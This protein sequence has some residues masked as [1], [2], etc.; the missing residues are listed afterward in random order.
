MARN[1][2]DGARHDRYWM[3]PILR[4]VVALATA[5]VITFTAGHSSHF[6]LNVFGAF[7]LASGLVVGIASI[8]LVSEPVTRAFFV[9]Q[10]VIGVVTGVLA[11]VLSGGGLGMLLYV[12]SVWAA[13]TGFLELYSGLRNRGRHPGAKDWTAVG[14]F[15]VLL[16]IATLL[17]PP[18]LEQ[19]FAAPGGI[20]GILRADIVVV[21]LVGA[22]AAI[23][24]V[25]LVIG[26]LSLKWAAAKQISP[27]NEPEAAL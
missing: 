27:S 21:G 19:R 3:V 11:L 18:G 2:I 20:E 25:F 15:T 4:A 1:P 8:R 5:G 14:A 7:A 24:G 9:G 13:L 23:I 26:G 16:A 6:G 12:V 22:Y 10:G 17:V